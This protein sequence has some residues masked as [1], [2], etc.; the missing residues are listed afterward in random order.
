MGAE[1]EGHIDSRSCAQGRT[2]SGVGPDPGLLESPRKRR[3]G[4]CG[5]GKSIGRSV[6]IASRNGPPRRRV[7]IASQL[8]VILFRNRI[9]PHEMEM[10]SPFVGACAA[11]VFAIADRRREIDG[12]F[13]CDGKLILVP[14]VE[15][16]NRLTN[17]RPEEVV[18]HQ[19]RR[20]RA[21]T[22]R[23]QQ[24][25]RASRTGPGRQKGIDAHPCPLCDGVQHR[26][27]ATRARSRE[28]IDV[29]A[30]VAS[31]YQE[32]GILVGSDEGLIEFLALRVVVDGLGDR[33]I[34]N[35]PCPG[36]SNE[37]R[38]PRAPGACD[39]AD[40]SEDVY[41]RNGSTDPHGEADAA[42]HG[43]GDGQGAPEGGSGSVLSE[44]GLRLSRPRIFQMEPNAR[45]Y[46][47]HSGSGL[48]RS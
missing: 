43:K 23:T 40:A 19:D 29:D 10:P 9:R 15:T 18:T 8:D 11:Q 13:R 6:V 47:R 5:V 14:P 26:V 41:L 28:Y 17:A 37:V 36:I 7:G 30:V 46:R 38:L 16:L 45:R 22:R 39:D 34:G 33:I 35:A 27:E 3:C 20:H 42:L 24:A 32:P 1:C 44:V 4:A 2:E 25:P 12:Q 31:R 48:G 21:E